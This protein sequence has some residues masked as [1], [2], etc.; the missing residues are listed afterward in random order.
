MSARSFKRDSPSRRRPAAYRYLIFH[1]P[2]DVLSQFTDRQGQRLTLKDY[3]PVGDVYPIGRLDRDSEGLMLLSNHGV[4]QHR[5]SDPTHG[6]PRTYWVQ[7]EGMPTP[8]ALAALATGVMVQ[9]QQTRPAE[10]QCLPTAPAL[11]P[12]VPPIRQRQTIPTCW[13]ALTLREGRNRQVRRMTA[14]VG[15]PTLRLVRVQ[16]GPLHLADLPQGQWRSLRVK[17]RQTLGEWV[18]LSL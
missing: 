4:L 7:V 12:R 8:E 17:E 5:L 3:I 13:L 6:H 10:V 2:Y 1:K 18:G 9:G 11:P 14:A 16:I 15:Y